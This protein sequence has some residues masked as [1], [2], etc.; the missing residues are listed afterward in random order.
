MSL[1]GRFG[2]A[3][4]RVRTKRREVD[5]RIQRVS[6][7]LGR[8]M[9]CTPETCRS[10]PWRWRR[11]RVPVMAGSLSG[12]VCVY[13]SPLQVTKG[14]VHIVH[15]YIS[16]ILRAYAPYEQSYPTTVRCT[17]CLGTH[18]GCTRAPDAATARPVPPGSSEP[19]SQS[20]RARL[21]LGEINGPSFCS[22]FCSFGGGVCRAPNR[23]HRLGWYRHR[24]L[25][26]R[27]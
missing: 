22:C 20:W 25:S 17:V 14:Q 19:E 16:Y 26:K 7:E 13:S 9:P 2:D 10:R 4:I 8:G 3:G 23:G 1:G 6:L 15:V 5:V 11:R 18:E 24:P 27:V 21:V 12:A